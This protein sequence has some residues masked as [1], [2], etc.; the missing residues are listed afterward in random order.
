MLKRLLAVCTL[1]FASLTWAAVDANKASEAELVQV[2]GI[3]PVLAGHIVE[4]RKAG[5]FKS[6]DDFITRV[7]GVGKA[8][9]DKFSQGGLTVDGKPYKKQEAELAK[10]GKKESSK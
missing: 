8:N 2:K 5:N 7:K 3:G 1:L 9:A 10:A 6:W 4:A